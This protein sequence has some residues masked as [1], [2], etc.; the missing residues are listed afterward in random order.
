VIFSL[1]ALRFSSKLKRSECPQE[2]GG[3]V[4]SVFLALARYDCQPENVKENYISTL[5]VVA[6]AKGATAQR[7]WT[8]SKKKLCTTQDADFIYLFS[9]ALIIW[10]LLFIGYT[11][12]LLW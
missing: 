2:S 7:G 10:E 4:W 1:C 3:V 9:R 11:S 12:M 8:A 5:F 6:G